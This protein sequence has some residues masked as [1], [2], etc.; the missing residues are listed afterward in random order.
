MKRFAKTISGCVL[1][2]FS[3]TAQS[4][5]IYENGVVDAATYGIGEEPPGVI[6]RPAPWMRLADPP[7]LGVVVG[8]TVIPRRKPLYSVFAYDPN[9]PSP[10]KIRHDR[11]LSL[12]RVDHEL[13]AV[14]AGH[15]KRRLTEQHLG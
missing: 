10:Q 2:V 3:A 8:I 9:S 1:A 6:G 14:G 13:P 15:L 12:G 5:V 4:P 11:K 7:P